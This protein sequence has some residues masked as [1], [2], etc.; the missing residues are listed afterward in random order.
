MKTDIDIQPVALFD[1]CWLEMTSS[2]LSH[3][4]CACSG[5]SGDFVLFPWL[6]LY[7]HFMELI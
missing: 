1:P 5:A 7:L 6:W 4:H 3:K 2:P